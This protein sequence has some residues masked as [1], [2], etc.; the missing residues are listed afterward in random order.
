MI[1]GTIRRNCYDSDELYLVI[2]CD[3]KNEKCYVFI[4]T[5]KERPHT[6]ERWNLF[7]CEEDEEIA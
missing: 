2:R 4:L 3:V 7:S 6:Y 1:T 5:G